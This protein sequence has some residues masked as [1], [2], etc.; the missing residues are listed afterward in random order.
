[1]KGRLD[2][3]EGVRLGGRCRRA[4]GRR[5]LATGPRSV[6]LTTTS[7]P[8]LP[9]L[10]PVRSR[11]AV[12]LVLVLLLRRLVAPL[13]LLLGSLIAVGSLLLA[14]LAILP[15]AFARTRAI[16]AILTAPGRTSGSDI[17]RA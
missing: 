1:M 12:L 14:R 15:L 16:A 10:S 6:R 3:E 13:A 17:T 4:I 2:K 9:T 5:R 11:I 8:P 7:V